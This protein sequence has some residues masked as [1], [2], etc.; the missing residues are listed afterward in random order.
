MLWILYPPLEISG[1]GLLRALIHTVALVEA[2]DSACRI[3]QLLLSGKERMASGAHLQPDFRFSGAGLKLVP[4]SAG[5]RDFIIFGMNSFF[6]FN[7]INRRTPI[8][9]AQDKTI[10]IP[11]TVP[12]IQ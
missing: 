1:L 4:T 5:D 7:L 10:N 9:A 11:A 12:I 8:R 2:F 3:D 6:H